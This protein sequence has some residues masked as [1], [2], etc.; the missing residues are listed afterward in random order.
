LGLPSDLLLSGRVTIFVGV[1][2]IF[3]NNCLFYLKYAW[4]KKL[5]TWRVV[6]YN[7]RQRSFKLKQ[8]SSKAE[9][10]EIKQHL[11][12]FIFFSYFKQ[13]QQWKVEGK[14]W[15]NLVLTLSDKRLAVL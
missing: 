8:F 5:F 12:P 15:R 11:N 4:Y 1:K 14:M 2:N 6:K 7:L 3:F 10:P 9:S 13:K